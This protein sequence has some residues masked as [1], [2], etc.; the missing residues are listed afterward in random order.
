MQGFWPPPFV[1]IVQGAHVDLGCIHLFFNL[2]GMLDAG[3]EKHG[4]HVGCRHENRG[5][6]DVGITKNFKMAAGHV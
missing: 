1:A 3:D 5:R 2:A 6:A 4:R